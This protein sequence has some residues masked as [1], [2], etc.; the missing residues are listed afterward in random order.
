MEW[1]ILDKGDFSGW[2]LITSNIPTDFYN[3]LLR[4]KNVFILE[5]DFQNWLYESS[6]RAKYVCDT[7]WF[8][9]RETLEESIRFA[10][11]NIQHCKKLLSEI[12]F[13]GGI[14][15]LRRAL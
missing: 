15:L 12:R 6:I 2:Q 14:C 5:A 1:C 4:D 10:N 7:F 11:A 13:Q 8:S 3:F 9:Q